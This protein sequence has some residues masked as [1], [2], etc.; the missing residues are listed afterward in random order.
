MQSTLLQTHTFSIFILRSTLVQ[1]PLKHRHLF[2]KRHLIRHIYLTFCGEKILRNA[3]IP[4]TK[5]SSMNIENQ[6][7]GYKWT[8]Q[9]W[10]ITRSGSKLHENHRPLARIHKTHPSSLKRKSE[11]MSFL[12]WHKLK[13]QLQ[14]EP[15]IQPVQPKQRSLS[16]NQE[17]MLIWGLSFQVTTKLLRVTI[18]PNPKR[19]Q[20][21]TGRT[22]KHPNAES[23][24]SKTLPKHRSSCDDVFSSSYHIFK[25]NEF[26]Y[27]NNKQP[28]LSKSTWIWTH[29]LH[30][31][32]LSYWRASLLWW[33]WAMSGENWYVV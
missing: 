33:W 20:H 6:T 4:K 22:W 30:A 8:N 3:I 21:A 19:C 13:I 18:R 29:W 14:R 15:K 10:D 24:I 5:F 16:E 11:T 12:F 9:V 27:D 31:L 23:I 25:V 28:T 2:K 32:L 26:K 17:I 1:S 7:T